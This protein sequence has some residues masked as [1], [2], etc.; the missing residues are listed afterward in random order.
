[1]NKKLIITIFIFLCLAGGVA[2]FNY[3]K[4]KGTEMTEEPTAETQTVDTDESASS[5]SGDSQMI[6]TTRPEDDP[7]LVQ[8]PVTDGENEYAYGGIGDD[9]IPDFSTPVLVD[10]QQVS[11]TTDVMDDNDGFVADDMNFVDT[12]AGAVQVSY[13]IGHVD[14]QPAV[15]I[16]VPKAQDMGENGVLRVLGGGVSD[17]SILYQ[18]RDVTI[19]E[20]ISNNSRSVVIFDKLAIDSVTEVYAAYSENNFEDV[21]W[22]EIIY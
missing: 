17:D 15:K 2:F 20:L 10:D 6:S 18:S 11:E 21:N 8:V 3:Q 19:D 7:S 1:M 4:S 9:S 22:S 14:D 5:S 12:W 16:Y 13:V